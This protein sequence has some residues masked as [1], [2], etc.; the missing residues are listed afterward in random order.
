MTAMTRRDVIRLAGAM[1]PIVSCGADITT[2]T[3]P[4]LE[5]LPADAVVISGNSVRVRVDRIAALRP[6]D[7]VVVLLAAR[8]IVVRT[9]PSAFRVLSAEC[10]HSG[11]GVSI[12]DRPRLI[13]PC[14]GSEF[15]LSGARLAGPTPTGLT[16]LQSEYNEASAELTV[17]R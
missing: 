9:G 3:P 8:I 2:V 10:P 6:A 15:N 4:S 11:C 12:V 1:L 13:C 7:G 17:S 16:L 14:H 5:E